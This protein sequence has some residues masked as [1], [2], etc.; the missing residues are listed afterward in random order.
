[1][2]YQDALSILQMDRLIAPILGPALA[3]QCKVSQIDH[4]TLKLIVGNNACASK[5]RQLGPSITRHLKQKGYLFDT[6]RIKIMPQMN[7]FKPTNPKVPTTDNN[8]HQY[9]AST[10]AFKALNAKITSGPLADTLKRILKE[11]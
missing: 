1:N 11:R 3:Q 7:S 5:I 9:Q 4:K 10:Q 2:I 6:I 8:K